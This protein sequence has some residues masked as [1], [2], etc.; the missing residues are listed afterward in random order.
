MLG[1]VEIDVFAQFFIQRFLS[2]DKRA[3]AISRRISQLL[4]RDCATW[5]NMGIVGYSRVT[6]GGEAFFS[7]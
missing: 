3:M 7:D 4:N 5:I 2:R 1:E 6:V